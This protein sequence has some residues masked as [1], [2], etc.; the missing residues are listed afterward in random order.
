M[1]EDS[2]EEID[3]SPNN[4]ST[5]SSRGNQVGRDQQTKEKKM[6]FECLPA[7]IQA[8]PRYKEA[9]GPAY[10]SIHNTSTMTRRREEG[11]DRG[12]AQIA[13]K[14]AEREEMRVYSDCYDGVDRSAN[15]LDDRGSPSTFYLRDRPFVV[16]FSLVHPYTLHWNDR[17]LLVGIGGR[18][19]NGFQ[20]IPLA[21]L[22][23]I[24]TTLKNPETPA[25]ISLNELGGE[26]VGRTE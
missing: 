24:K 23:V 17:E 3:E 26:V 9:T 19:G 11:S 8:A 2:R 21:R 18:S 6:A 14:V 7:S 5:V 1:Y 12:K 15:L 13:Y 4:K 10:D 20:S 16:Y 22:C 25:C